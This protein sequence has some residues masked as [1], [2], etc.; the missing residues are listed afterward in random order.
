MN[1]D[2]AFD[3][4]IGH[5]GGYANHPRD[6]GGETMWGVTA[7]VA[8]ANGYKGKMIDLPRE[9]AK[10]IYRADYWEPCRAD[11]LPECIRFDVFDA[12]VNSGVGQAAR[13]LQRA[14]SVADDGAIG[15]ITVAAAVAVG[16]RL[17]ARFNGHRLQFMTDLSTW[18]TFGKG[19]ARRVASNLIG[20]DNG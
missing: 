16:E 4:L 12:A 8:R 7:Q 13:W 15:P 6:P 14:A 9:T 20:H 19:W 17:P 1:F 3:I 5:E 2:A 10:A 18:P 11:L